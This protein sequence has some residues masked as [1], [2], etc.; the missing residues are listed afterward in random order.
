MLPPQLQQLPPQPVLLPRLR[1][2]LPQ[3]PLISLHLQVS[4]RL[5]PTLFAWGLKSLGYLMVIMCV[6]SSDFDGYLGSTCLESST[7]LHIALDDAT[8]AV[9]SFCSRSFTWTSAE[10]APPVADSPSGPEVKF[11]AS[12]NGVSTIGLL[13]PSVKVAPACA[14][15]TYPRLVT[16]KE[17]R[18][19][20]TRLLAECKCL[21]FAL[22]L[23]H[24]VLF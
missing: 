5:P 19:G 9:E 22:Q 11:Q 8:K 2:L 16:Q 14:T 18:A 21:A 13:Y 10:Q 7:T 24:D 4:L 17:C 20:Y 6:D 23:S 1:Y 12:N 15:G 3:L